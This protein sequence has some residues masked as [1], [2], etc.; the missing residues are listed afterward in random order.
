MPPLPPWLL[1]FPVLGFL[2]FIHELG[3][4]VTAKLFGVKV[5]EF[6][7]GWPGPRI[8][9][10]K[11]RDTLYSIT[12]VPFGG[13]VRFVGEEDP[14][15]PDSFA[16]QSV[17]KRT[18]VL[19]AGSFMNLLFPVVFF[20]AMFMFPHDALV[21]ADVLITSVAPGSPAQ[22]AGFRTGDTIL[23]VNGERV[24]SPREL[25]DAI[26]ANLGKPVE[27]SIRRGSP[28]TGF[29]TSPEFMVVEAVEV[30]PRRSP[31]RLQVVDEVGDPTS[32]VSLAEAR[33]YNRELEVGDTMTQGAVGVMIGLANPRV[34]KETDPIWRAVPKSFST[35]W[36]ILVFT[37]NGLAEGVK[38]RTNPGVAGPVGIA[39]ATGEVVTELGFAWVFQFTALISI[40]LAVLNVLPLPPLD[41]GRLL[42]VGIEWVRRGKRISPQ[43]EGLV[44]LVGFAVLIA[45]LLV[46][47]Y[48]DVLRVL[49][50][51]SLLR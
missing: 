31:P 16:R 51:E 33:R 24:V 25:V 44:H 47:S 15:D 9:S 8:V 48:F 38:T 28:I 13:F 2:I 10:L 1:I 41:G 20:T 26:R 40:S 14:S 4:F 12:W 19:L 49:S 32:E 23:T 34:A 46:M 37:W 22:E 7:F 11:Y 21:G 50:G 6:A 17:I 39:Q 35:I 18:V 5:T 36:D 43:R 45:F 29:G 27:L 30:V 3:H 42:F